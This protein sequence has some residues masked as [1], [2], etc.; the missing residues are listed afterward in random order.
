M[1][2]LTKKE[3]LLLAI[4]FTALI[5]GAIIHVH[6][7]RLSYEYK[8]NVVKDPQLPRDHLR[9][10]DINRAV[11]NELTMLSGIGPVLAGRIIAYREEHGPFR[12]K[13]DITKV[14]GI[15]PKKYKSIQE[16]ISISGSDRHKK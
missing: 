10:L 4:I 3:Q 6:K 9:I 8:I 15:G 1:E 16:H 7:I 14:K 2:Q 13:E 12:S 5:I 11:L